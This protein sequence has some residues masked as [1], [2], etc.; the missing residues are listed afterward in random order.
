MLLHCAQS[1]KKQS[2]TGLVQTTKSIKLDAVILV[3]CAFASRLP[4]EVIVKHLKHYKQL[5]AL[6]SN[7]FH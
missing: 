1:P 4:L 7:I 3:N 5:L 2:S 6:F